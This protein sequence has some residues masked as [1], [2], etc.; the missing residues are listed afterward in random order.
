MVLELN[1]RFGGGY[2]FSHV[3]GANIPAAIIAWIEGA[4]P[5]SEWFA[6]RPGVATAK[7]DQ[8]IITSVGGNGFGVCTD[9][10]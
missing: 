8:L 6:V 4:E 9:V 1:P 3:A 7:Y 5:K 10:G 2:P